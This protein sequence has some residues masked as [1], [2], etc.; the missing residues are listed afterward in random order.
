[1][2]DETQT[3]PEQISYSDALLAVVAIADGSL[4]PD[5]I[6]IDYLFER[7]VLR[8]GRDYTDEYYSLL[9]AKGGALVLEAVKRAGSENEEKAD[10]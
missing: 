1:M 9:T 3:H 6:E 10:D 2:P 5:D 8:L 7:G 4:L